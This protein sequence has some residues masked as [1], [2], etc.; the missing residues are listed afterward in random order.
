MQLTS[1][2]YE[3]DLEKALIMSKLEFEEHKQ[4]PYCPIA[5]LELC[6]PNPMDPDIIHRVFINN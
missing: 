1:E 6:Y 5:A 2:L 3:A 4:V